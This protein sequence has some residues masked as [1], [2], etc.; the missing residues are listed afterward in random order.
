MPPVVCLVFVINFIEGLIDFLF[1]VLT[2]EYESFAQRGCDD[3]SLIRK[4]PFDI[5]LSF[6]VEI[7]AESKGLSEVREAIEGY[8]VCIWYAVAE[9]LLMVFDTFI[10]E[11]SLVDFR[12][13]C[14]RQGDVLELEGSDLFV[15]LGRLN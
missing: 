12:A 13:I 3:L 6:M 14:N 11:V 10:E 15:A 4:S 7:F 2:V 8:F 1:C 5:Q 9:D